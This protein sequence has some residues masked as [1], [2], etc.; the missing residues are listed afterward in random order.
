MQFLAPG[1]C[2]GNRCQNGGTCVPSSDGSYSCNCKEGFGGNECQLIGMIGTLTEYLHKVSNIKYPTRFR[3]FDIVNIF[4]KINERSGVA[5]EENSP[6]LVQ[7]A[8]ITCVY[9]LTSQ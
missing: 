4:K 1:P 7:F 5:G 9:I 3:H 2:T 8:I 6:C